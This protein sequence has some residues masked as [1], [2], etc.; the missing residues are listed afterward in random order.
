MAGTGGDGSAP[1]I[2]EEDLFEADWELES[3][4]GLDMIISGDETQ[5]RIFST[6]LDIT[7]DEV[8]VIR[9]GAGKWPA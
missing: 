6:I 3:I 2:P 5:S 7:E 9:Q 4:G 8:R 1:D